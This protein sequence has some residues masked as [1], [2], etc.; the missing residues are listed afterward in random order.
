M[1]C[2]LLIYNFYILFYISKLQLHNTKSIFK[3][4]F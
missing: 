2:N 4:F 1:N 3:L